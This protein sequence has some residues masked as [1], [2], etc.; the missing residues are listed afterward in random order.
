M[1]LF[2][3]LN[4][5]VL[6]ALTLIACGQTAVPDSG[7]TDEDGVTADACG[8]DCDL[9]DAATPSDVAEDVP[10]AGKDAGKD[11][12]KDTAVEEVAD[13]TA[14]GDAG[15]AADAPD[16]KVDAGCDPIPAN[17]AAGSLIVNEMMIYPKAVKDAMGEWVEL[18]N[19][20]AS[21]IALTGLYLSTADNNSHTVYACGLFVPPGGVVTLC[22]NADKASNGGVNCDYEYGDDIKLANVQGGIALH[23]AQGA[24]ATLQDSATWS[25]TPPLTSGVSWSLDP[26]HANATDNDNSDFWC[27][28]AAAYGSGDL[29]TPG[30]LNAD[31]PKPVDTDSDGIVDGKDNCPTVANPDQLDADGDK[32]GDLCDN[33]LNNP[34]LDQLDTDGDGAGD[35]CDAACCGDAELDSKY[36]SGVPSANCGNQTVTSEQCD[37]GNQDNDDGCTTE[38]KVAPVVPVELVITEIMAVPY[39]ADSQPGEWLEIYN[40]SAKAIDLTGWVLKTTKQGQATLPALTI[41]PG[42]RLTLGGS[43]DKLYN[44][45]AQVDWAWPTT[46]GLDDADDTVSLLH[47]SAVVDSVHYGT[48]TPTPVSGKALQLDPVYQTIEANNF[49]KFWCQADAAINDADPTSSD[50]GT[51]DKA[52]TSCIPVGKDKDGDG[53]KNEADNCPFDTNSDQKDTDGDGLGDVCDNCPAISNVTQADGD[54]DGVGDVCD[55]CP[56]YAN[57]DQKDTDGDGFGDY[58]DSLTCG[59]GKL[60]QYEVCDDNNLN[61]GDGCSHTCQIESFSPGAIIISEFMVK[62]AAVTDSLGEWLELFN[63]TDQPIDISGWNLHDDLTQKHFISPGVPFVVPAKGFRVLGINGDKAKNGGVPVDYVYTDFTLANTADA[64]DLAWNGVEIDDVKYIKQTPSAAGFDIQDGKSLSLDPEHLN[65]AD[66]D[67]AGNYCPGKFKWAGSAGDLGTPGKMNVTCKNPC[68]NAADGTPCDD[69]TTEWCQATVCVTKPYCGDKI[70]QLN[71]GEQCDDG[72]TLAGDGCD[73]LC[74]IEVK[75]MPDGTL[76]ITEIQANP[77]AVEDAA[78]DWLELFNPTSKPIDLTGWKLSDA[79]GDLHTIGATCGDGLTETGEECDDH[80]TKA[81]D[82]CDATCHVEGSCTLLQLNG[83]TSVVTVAPATTLPFGKTLTLHGWFELDELYGNGLCPTAVGLS[84]CSDLFSYGVSGD[85]S[86]GARIQGGKLRAFVGAAAFDLADAVPGQWFHLALSYDNGKLYALLNGAIV[87]QVS[88]GGWPTGQNAGVLTVGGTQEAG[89]GNLLHPLKGSVASFQASTAFGAVMERVIGP[90]VK[91]APA[92]SN[93]NGWRG[94]L[95]SIAFDDGTGTTPVDLKGNTVNATDA[96]WNITSGPYCKDA[97]G[98]VGGNSSKTPGASALTIPAG[99]YAVIAQ[100][101]DLTTNND[102]RVLYGMADNGAPVTFTLSNGGDEVILTNPAGGMV[103][104][105]VYDSTFPYGQGYAMMLQST[106]FDTTAN[107]AATCWQA[108]SAGSC[109]YGAYVANAGSTNAKCGAGLAACIA[110]EVCED[111]GAGDFAC[112]LKDRGTPGALNVCP[113]Q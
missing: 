93:A 23:N 101:I 11:A 55:N 105:V 92:A 97:G 39:N 112:H 58:C 38:C 32:A 113:G 7:G 42:T 60:E 102:V 45:A 57:G 95:V 79:T 100:R 110:S 106:C 35:A 83:T 33:C 12:A 98:F 3:R 8:V 76:I 54:H 43:I 66:N 103:D 74:H 2:S 52:N 22:R 21:P 111:I 53:V 34:N 10:D 107:D 18:L 16:V 72:G 51:P 14:T 77:D 19:T 91:W 68:Q 26:G 44:G 71:L 94:D 25:F 86:F 5:L 13:T 36:P 27:N 59:N 70:I 65:A 82:G 24:S 48:Q 67:V 99:G 49:A 96:T 31:C 62:P 75:P 63:T 29:G 4:L 81:N 85:A 1:K 104:T 6:S 40:G 69:V 64:I 108:A 46:F 80:N 73:A 28:G 56:L 15:D 17:L 78:G 88:V 61:S 89:T 87:L 37:D 50:F 84:A 47:G 30:A 90:Q 20:T 9:A 109:A 41:Q